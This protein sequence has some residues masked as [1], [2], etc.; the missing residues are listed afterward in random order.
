MAQMALA[1]ADA[2]G[3]GHSL[4]GALAE[5]ARGVDGAAGHELRRAGGGAGG[6]SDH[7][8]GARGD[9]RAAPSARLDALVSACLLQRR[10]GGDLA[11]LL[12]ESARAM[13]DQGRLEDEVKA[14]TAQARFTGLIVV[15]LPLG[16]GAARR[17]GEPRVVRGPLE[18]VPHRLAR[19]DRAR[20]PGDRGRA[21]APARA[22]ALVIPAALAFL[23]AASAAAGIVLIAP[24]RASAARARPGA[25]VLRLLAA[26]RSP[27]GEDHGGLPR[28]GPRRGAH[29]PRGPYR[30]G[31]PAGRARRARADGGQARR[32][33]VAGALGAAVGSL[34]PGRLGFLVT[35]AAPVGGFLA[36]DLWLHRLAGRACAARAARAAGAARSAARDGRGRRVARRGAPARW[37]ARRR[38]ARRTSCARR[39]RGGARRAARGCARRGSAGACPCRR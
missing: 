12:R 6:G 17:A 35:L 7:G 8:R 29:R 15:L 2:L 10:A 4:R 20:A 38:A 39:G 31:G 5:A 26:R 23:A 11:R 22:G 14:A 28:S 24:S 3:G 18:H 19:R 37:G 9:A 34:A 32:A 13:E 33:G 30:G 1:L 25:G 21:D 16:G 36:P 27:G